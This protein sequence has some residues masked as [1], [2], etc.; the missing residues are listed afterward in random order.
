MQYLRV[1]K[2]QSD[3]ILSVL[4]LTESI[5]VTGID[6]GKILVW[7]VGAGE[8]V[9]EMTQHSSEVFSLAVSPNRTIFASAGGDALVKIFDAKSFECLKSIKCDGPIRKVCFISNDRL[10]AGVENSELAIID[11]AE[12]KIMKSLEKHSFP[13]G[14]EVP[15]PPVA[16]TVRSIYY[17]LAFILK[18]LT[19]NPE[20]VSGREEF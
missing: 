15:N 18:Y 4:F 8:K 16:Y 2:G 6:D 20:L 19:E 5:A 12:G 10:V 1:F 14:I 9:K 11:V 17:A 7:N 13:S 3:T